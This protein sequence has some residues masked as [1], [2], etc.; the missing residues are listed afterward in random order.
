MQPNYDVFVAQNGEDGFRRLENG[1]C[2]DNNHE[3]SGMV[4]KFLKKRPRKD[5]W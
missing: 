2:C 1:S 4:V 5:V 3:R